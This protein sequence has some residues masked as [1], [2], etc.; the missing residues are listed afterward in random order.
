MEVTTEKTIVATRMGIGVVISF[1]VTNYF[2]FV[3]PTWV[4]ISFFVVSFEPRTI[5]ASLMRSSMRAIAT[6]S[7]AIY[8]L[9]IILLFNNYYLMNMAG[10]VIGIFIYTYLFLGTNKGYIGTIGSL[11]LAICLINYNDLSQVFIRSANVLIGIL[12]S[13]FVMRHIFPRK[14]VDMLILEFNNML[15]EFATLASYLVQINQSTPELQ[16]R[17]VQFET[18]MMPA[19]PRFQ[20]LI[21]DSKL[22]LPPHS[23]F[24]DITEDILKSLRRIF[25]YY[26]SFTDSILLEKV[27]LK[28]QDKAFLLFLLQL[29]QKLQ[30]SIIHLTPRATLHPLANLKLKEEKIVSPFMLHLIFLEFRALEIKTNTLLTMLKTHC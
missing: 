11:T 18:K 9:I 26:T 4:Y 8:S 3:D 20:T 16:K 7:S 22:E 1:V 25:R 15:T 21:H 24:T 29:N 19:I 30:A 6:V 5:G 12:I 14:A 10:L 23:K 27:E 28:N 17:L 2:T 13:T